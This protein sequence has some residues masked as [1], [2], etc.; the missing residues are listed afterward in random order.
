[1]A[2]AA[3]GKLASAVSRSGGLGMNGGGYGDSAWLK[4]QFA[5]AGGGPA[6]KRGGQ[7]FSLCNTAR[8]QDL[9]V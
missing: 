7:A 1:M 6:I 9:V 5:K 2:F 4:K 3:G 8:R